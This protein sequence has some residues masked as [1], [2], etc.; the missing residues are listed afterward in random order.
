MTLTQ[1]STNLKTRQVVSDLLRFIFTIQIHKRKDYLYF[2]MCTITTTGY[3]D[4]KP[5]TPYTKFLC[6]LAN[7]T[8]FFFIVVFFNTLLSLRRRKEET[9]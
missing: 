4:I 5:M 7:M 6:T 1:N 2:A 8:E 9:T 3:G